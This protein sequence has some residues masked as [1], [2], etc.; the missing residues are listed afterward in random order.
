VKGA[1][2]L[3]ALLALLAVGGHD[4]QAQSSPASLPSAPLPDST[5][6]TDAA[7]QAEQQLHQTFTN[8][9]FEDFGPAPVTGP[10][11]QAS[12][13]GK[14]IYYAPIATTSFSPPSMTATAS[15]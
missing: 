14:I 13:G 2:T 7:R 5:V 15:M 12:A 1:S 4:A 10:L 3:S 9:H 6:L 8:L 11:Y